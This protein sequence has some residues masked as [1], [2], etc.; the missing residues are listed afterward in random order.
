V[1]EGERQTAGRFSVAGEASGR[2]RRG[3]GHGAAGVRARPRR[4]AQHARHGR[5]ESGG[6]AG[7]RREGG[8]ASVGPTWR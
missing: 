3:A 6:G 1:G 7:G 8:G 5:M 4:T 2:G